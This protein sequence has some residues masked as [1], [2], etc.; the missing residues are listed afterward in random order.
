MAQETTPE[1]MAVGY[2]GINPPMRARAD[3]AGE[4][5]LPPT[6]LP[7][8]ERLTEIHSSGMNVVYKAVDSKLGRVVAIDMLTQVNR[9]DPVA[10]ARFRSEAAILAKLDHPNL[11]RI[12]AYDEH[13]SSPYLVQEY[14]EGGSLSLYAKAVRLSKQ[15]IAL[16]I[17]PIARGVQVIHDHGIIHRD[18]KPANVL[19][20]ADGVPKIADFGLAMRLTG[21]SPVSSDGKVLGSL[22][23]MA[24]ELAHPRIPLSTAADIYSLGA[25]LFEIL[26]G[27]PPMVG[28]TPMD[29]AMKAKALE[30]VSPRTLD[31]TVPLDLEA[32]CMKCLRRDPKER[33]KSAAAFA[34]DL[35]R[36][37]SGEPIHAR[38]IGSIERTLK[39]SKRRPLIATLAIVLL[40]LLAVDLVG[41][42]LLYGRAV[43][44]ER[45]AKEAVESLM[46][47]KEK[48]IVNRLQTDPSL[49]SLRNHPDFKKI[50]A[51]IEA[52]A[53]Q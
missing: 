13:D 51:D 36:F 20:T 10:V 8:F 34:D 53:K 47:E 33:Y 23:F 29:T 48:D 41:L 32:I 40:A 6:D 5:P 49:Q 2:R 22:A 19:V 25:I 15:E 43:D 31:P 21:N 12:L 44:G 39:W 14:V 7:G 38:S 37:V 30:V 27:R 35:R 46:Q 18:L 24:P 1:K 4:K 28:S 52:K 9:H 50:V 3:S 11:S 26:A 16:L 45:H 17:E 42:W